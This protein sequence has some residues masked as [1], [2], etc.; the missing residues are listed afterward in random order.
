MPGSTHRALRVLLGLLCFI[1]GVV[2][3]VSIFADKP[4]LLRLLLSPPEAEI[5]TLLLAVL[6]DMGGVFLLL[7]LMSFFA[8]RDPVR[9]VAFVDAFIAG[10]CV[11]AVTP[12]L[13]LYTLDLGRL[14]PAYLIWGRSVARLV[15]AALLL[16]LRPR[17]AAVA[18][19]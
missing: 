16:Y 15:V 12:L 17:E 2:G 5:S 6:K 13:S 4:L 11:L 8:A 18:Q 7:S 1:T 9:N 10:S 3:L 14:F 19:G